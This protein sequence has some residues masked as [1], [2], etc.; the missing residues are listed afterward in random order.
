MAMDLRRFQSG[1]VLRKKCKVKWPVMLAL[2]IVV[3]FDLTGFLF[4][5]EHNNH[6]N[7]LLPN[8]T[9]EVLS[10]C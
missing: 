2:P 10:Q 8:N 9:P 7:V 5:C 4:G 3:S 6:S 1:A